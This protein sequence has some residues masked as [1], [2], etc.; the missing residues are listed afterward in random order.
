MSATSNQ[1]PAISNQRRNSRPFV[2]LLA[3]GGWLLAA[4]Y[5]LL[6]AQTAWAC[7][8]CK[9]IVAGFMSRMAEGYFWSIILL[10]SMPFIVVSLIAWRVIRAARRRGTAS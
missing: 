1:Q 10:V 3:A 4:S 2:V 7:A 5:E 9:D 8:M 6:T